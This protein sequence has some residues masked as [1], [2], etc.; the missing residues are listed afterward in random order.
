[1]YQ[2][3]KAPACC[4]E[5]GTGQENAF[6]RPTLAS[7]LA[8]TASHDK[9]HRETD[10]NYLGVI[11]REGDWRVITCRD[12]IQWIMQRRRR[13]ERAAGVRWEAV[14]YYLSRDVLIA[15]W[16]KGTGTTSEALNDLSKICGRESISESKKS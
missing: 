12:G 5:A 13:S 8:E 14:G 3:E 9:S 4:S 11:A 10:E 7:H 1:M 2:N 16:R 6:D 15:S